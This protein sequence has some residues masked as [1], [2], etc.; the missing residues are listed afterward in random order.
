MRRTPSRSSGGS[1]VEGGVDSRAESCSAQSGTHRIAAT[2]N[3]RAPPFVR[4]AGAGDCLPVKTLTRT[5]PNGQ[6]SEACEA[7]TLN[8]ATAAPP[9]PASVS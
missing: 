6:H 7:S 1:E 8:K 4:G 9:L 2:D 5:S 3:A